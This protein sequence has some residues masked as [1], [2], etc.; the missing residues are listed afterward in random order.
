[1]YPKSMAISEHILCADDPAAEYLRITKY[2]RMHTSVGLQNLS[3]CDEGKT[4]LNEMMKVANAAGF[5]GTPMFIV[6]GE[7]IEGANPKLKELIK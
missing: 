6:D 3:T 7:L 5:T 1:M 4:Q 2:I